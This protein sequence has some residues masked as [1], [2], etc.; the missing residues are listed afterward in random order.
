[1]PM[2]IGQMWLERDILSQTLRW[3]DEKLPQWTLN[4]IFTKTVHAAKMRADAGM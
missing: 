1:M 3:Q 4:F 2:V